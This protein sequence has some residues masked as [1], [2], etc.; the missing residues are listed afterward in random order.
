M[1]AARTIAVGVLTVSDRCAA[2][3]REDLS[4]ERIVQ[5]CDARGFTVRE[6]AVVPDETD[7]I[8]SLLAAWADGEMDLVITTGGTGVAPR[9]VT[10]EATR[11]VVERELPGVAEEIRRAGLDATPFSVLSRG[12]AGIRGSSIIVNLPGS[13]GGVSDGLD[14]LAPL[15]EH[16]VALARGDDPS[17]EAPEAR[18]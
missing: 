9:D 5:W 11:A 14:V 17:H 10:P 13:P 1:S 18:S 6:R 3:E 8:V 7:R 16:A 12:L 2:G 4:G 15:V